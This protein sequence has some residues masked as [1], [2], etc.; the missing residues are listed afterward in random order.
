MNPIRFHPIAQQIYIVTSLRAYALSRRS[1]KCILKISRLANIQTLI[2]LKIDLQILTVLFWETDGF[3]IFGSILV[4]LCFPVLS[5]PSIPKAAYSTEKR[6]SNSPMIGT[7][8]RFFFLYEVGTG[9]KHSQA[10]ELCG[11]FSVF[12]GLLFL[13]CRLLSHFPCGHLSPLSDLPSPPP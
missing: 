13:L 7:M 9:E 1:V 5:P 2:S 12:Q 3:Q 11:V 10:R 4:N 8:C 6:W